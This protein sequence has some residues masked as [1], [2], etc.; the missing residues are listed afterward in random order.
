MRGLRFRLISSFLP[1]CPLQGHVQASLLNSILLKP[2]TENMHHLFPP[3]C[4]KKDHRNFSS[5]KNT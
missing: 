4:V 5:T 1:P 2:E 3:L